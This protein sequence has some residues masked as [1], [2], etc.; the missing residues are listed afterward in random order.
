MRFRPRTGAARV[1][2]AVIAAA[3][4][5]TGAVPAAAA[6]TQAYLF[7]SVQSFT[8]AGAGMPG[9]TV[10]LY[11][12]GEHA[13]SP[14]V[15]LDTS[16]LAGIATIKFPDSCKVQGTT[17]TC[18]LP[19]ADAIEETEPLMFQAADT[20]TAGAHGT[21]TVTSKADNVEA[22]TRTTEVTIADGVDLV[23]TG[24]NGESTAKVR[25]GDVVHPTPLDF[26]NAGN[27]S[28]AGFSLLVHFDHQLIPDQYE[29]C[30][31]S[32]VG[33]IDTLMA[34]DFPDTV[35]PGDGIELSGLAVTIGP[36]AYVAAG[37]DY[38]VMPAGEG[39]PPSAMGLRRGTDGERLTV[40]RKTAPPSATSADIDESDNYAFFGVGGIVN[41]LDVAALPARITGTVGQT[42]RVK[43]GIHNI[44]P[45]ALNGTRSGEPAL[46][47]QFIVPAGVRVVSAPQT[48]ASIVEKD[49]V[50][51]PTDGAP[52]G[53]YYRCHTGVFLAAGAKVTAEFGVKIT[54][55]TAPAGSV[56][57]ND[58]YA[59]PPTFKDDNL[60]NN[61]APVTVAAPGGQGGGEGLPITGAKA[62]IVG[63]TGALTLVAGGLVLLMARRRR[64]VLVAGE[65]GSSQG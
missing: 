39:T 40:T 31:Y 8:M 57:L 44:G 33:A 30:S 18:A 35:A 41:R 16:G 28:S 27:K 65:D 23:V 20:A 53:T 43:V 48:C 55:L 59:I 15:T 9:K 51:Y 42:V 32:P 38:F 36:D 56:T 6:D 61:T 19:T 62:G 14:T 3:A 7:A 17:A 46:W 29:N 25:P 11:V 24:G 45:A 1:G 21:L 64:V 37:I 34:C 10:P 26:Y 54:S 63:G 13:V 4:V 58:R 52:G 22:D 50:Q 47:F 12:T 49:G 2:L 60:A 5:L